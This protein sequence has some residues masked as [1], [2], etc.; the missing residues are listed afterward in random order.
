MFNLTPT[1]RN[2]LLANLVIYLLQVNLRLNPSITELGSLYPLGSP[3]FHFWQFFSYMFLHDPLSWGHIITNMFGLISFG[4]MLEQRWG[5]QRFLA[6]W[7][8]CGVGAG[9][10]YEGVRTYELHKLEVAYTDFVRSPTA[11]DYDQFM[12]QSGFRQEED[13][14]AAA[15]FERNPNDQELRQAIVQ[16]VREVYEAVHNSPRNGMLGAS[17]ALFGVLF[18][19]AYL[20]PNTE[21]MLLFFPF[22]IKAKYFVF[23]YGLYE[24]YSGVHQASGDNV[25]HFAHIGGLLIGFI[26]LKFWE[27]GR[28]RFY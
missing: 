1:V 21:L 22:P 5:G 23:F 9:V 28:S 8:M 19:F 13:A 18:A 7:L 11:G 3:Y 2:L 26:I 10:L 6:F 12:E 25:A 24:L 27:S 15:A 16:H 4:P 17:G 14:T 20:F